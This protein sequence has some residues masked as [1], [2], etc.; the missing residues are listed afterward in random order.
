MPTCCLEYKLPETFKLKLECR[1][2]RE[3]ILGVMPHHWDDD[4]HFYQD[5]REDTLLQLAHFRR[6]KRKTLKKVSGRTTS[7]PFHKPEENH[8]PGKD[9]TKK[10]SNIIG[11]AAKYAGSAKHKKP[12]NYIPTITN[13]TQLW[14]L[15]NVIVAHLKEGI[16][17]I[18]LASGRTLCKL[19]LQEGGLHADINGD[20]V[21]DHVQAVGGNGAEQT[22]VSGSMEV[23]RPC[24]AVATSGVPVREQLFNASICHHSHFNL[25]QHGEFSRGF[26]RNPDVVSLEVATPILIPRSD[27]HRHRKGSHGDVIFLT[28]RGEVTAYSPASHGHDAVWQWQLLT[29]AT[30]SN[31]PSPSGMMEANLVVPTLKAFSLR[32]HDNQQMILAAGDQE[33]VVLSPGGSILTSVDLPAP[34]T[35]ALVCE[36]F[37]NDGLTDLILMTSNGVYGFVQTRQPGAL[38]FSTLVGCLIVVMGI[39]FITQHL[40]S[41]KGKPRAPS[42][43]R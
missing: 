40:N 9:S 12:I 10:I 23:L 37:S 1:E 26:G 19:H 21:L 27:G 41:M 42:G 2:F 31:L 36:D 4:M 14:W 43:L 7:Y 18:H 34:P 17:V 16:E 35:H 39:I 28:N 22:V 29:G 20:G 11:K 38:F 33:A 32:V 24:W 30:W 8:P 15:P 6:H 3:S 25:F 5:R 13:Y